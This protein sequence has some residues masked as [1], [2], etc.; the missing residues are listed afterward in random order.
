MLIQ[1]DFGATQTGIGYRFYAPADPSQATGALTTFDGQGAIAGS[2]VIS[3]QLIAGPG[4]DS[5]GTAG[6]SAASNEAGLLTADFRRGASYKARRGFSP[7]TEFTVPDA[8]SFALPE[9]LGTP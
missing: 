2:V 4:S 3:F 8:G 5:Y 7:W 9:I 1:V 6:F